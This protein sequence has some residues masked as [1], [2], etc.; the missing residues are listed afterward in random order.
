MHIAVLGAG[1]A[2]V[3]T[4]WQLLKDGHKVTIV[5]RESEAANFTS[6]GNAGLIAPGH[7]YAWASPRAPAMMWRSL[8][9]GDQA[10]RFKPRLDP[11]Q[12]SWMR[13]F[14][15]E[16]TAERATINTQVKARLCIYSQRMLHE[17]AAETGITYDRVTGGLLYFYRSPTTFK[18]AVAKC[19]ILRDCG[20]P[21]EALDT[22]A[23]IAKDPGLSA[24]RE[25]IAGALY[26]PGDEGGDCRIFTQKLMEACVRKGAALM[27]GATI[28][29]ITLA[30][31]EVASVET[32][33]GPVVADAYVLCLGVYSPHLAERIGIRLPIYPVKGYS[34]T[35][36]ITDKSVVARLGGVDEDNLFAYCPFGERMRFTATAEIAGYSNAHEPGDFRVM[37]ERARSL[38]PKGLAYDKA[39]HWAGLRPM[40]PTAVPII[41]RSPYANLFLNAGHGHMGWTMSNGSARIVADL[42]GQKK[43]AIEHAGFE[44]AA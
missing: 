7:A 33:K 14:L 30:N 8:W 42:I 3:T 40:T 36:P 27:L 21:I 2:G 10:I 5:D 28:R 34:M 16:C 1:I 43:L 35:I 32:D 26:V 31:G 18:A 12:W 24:A 41:D 17:V 13:K 29:N 22:P 9:R 39:T 20:I 37:M 44:H 4:A 6:F 38:F 11:R 23:A 25:Q 19:Q 15:A